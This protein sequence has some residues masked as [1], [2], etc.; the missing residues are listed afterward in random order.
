MQYQQSHTNEHYNHVIKNLQDYMLTKDML[1]INTS[2]LDDNIYNIKPKTNDTDNKKKK[3]ADLRFFSPT[4][5]DGLFWCFYIMNNGFASY[6]YPGN[7]SFVNE[8]TEKFRCIELLRTKKPELKKHK[9]VKIV[10]TSEEELANS[11]RIGMKT[12]LAICIGHS[13]NVIIIKKNKLYEL[14][15]NEDEPFHCVHC[16]EGPPDRYFYEGVIDNVVAAEYKLKYIRWENVDK[17]LKSIS[18]YKTDEMNE[19][20]DKVFNLINPD[21]TKDSISTENKVMSTKRKTK[22]EIYEYLIQNL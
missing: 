8:K 3:K 18:A 21:V 13:K 15:C 4:E 12:F 10:D 7:T 5:K 19:M 14:I 1:S 11:E 9:I 17:S 20:Y 22:K 6:E 2:R 16:E